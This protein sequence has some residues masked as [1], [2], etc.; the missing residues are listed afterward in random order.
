[1]S[2]KKLFDKSELD[3]PAPGKIC[4]LHWFSRHFYDELVKERVMACWVALS[5]LEDLP[6]LITVRNAG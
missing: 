2:F 1:V 6:V 5:R 4:T 3:P